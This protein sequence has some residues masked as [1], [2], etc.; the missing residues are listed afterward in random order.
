MVKSGIKTT[1]FWL[2]L[3]VTVL[4]ILQQQFWPDSP[5]PSDAFLAVGIWIAARL[6]EK[7]LGKVDPLT[8]KRAWQT[9][10]FWVTLGF[11][12]LKYIFPNLP[13]G[14]EA[15]VFSYII[16]RPLV[17]ISQNTDIT[18]LFTKKAA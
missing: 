3:I 9:T 8:G 7:T 12:V 17:K 2:G 16:G 15:F 14:L 13:A 1:E 4:T 18:K 10:E 6:G 5:F 11:G